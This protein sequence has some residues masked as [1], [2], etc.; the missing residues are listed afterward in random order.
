MGSTAPTTGMLVRAVWAPS[1]IAI[2]LVKFVAYLRRPWLGPRHL[3][4]A[5]WS[6]L[7]LGPF[8]AGL[9][10]VGLA[11]MLGY[12][13]QGAPAFPF[14]CLA[15]EHLRVQTRIYLVPPP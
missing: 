13:A 1:A 5:N 3:V 11:S 6:V 4:L 15:T 10:R 9:E 7:S 12:M 14:L 8:E 2:K